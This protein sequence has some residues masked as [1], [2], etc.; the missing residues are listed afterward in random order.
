VETLQ[1]TIAASFMAQTRQPT[2]FPAFGDWLR[3]SRK[4]AGK[5]QQA[6]LND[7]ERRGV[8]ITK[9][10]LS[11]YEGG[12]VPDPVVLAALAD[13]YGESLADAIHTLHQERT[14]N[15]P[16]RPKTNLTF[17]NV[18][19]YIPKKN[20]GTEGA[21]SRGPITRRPDP[22]GA[23][24][25]LQPAPLPYPLTEHEALEAAARLFTTAD[26]LL[27]VA[28]AIMRATARRQI[29]DPR[30]ATPERARADRNRRR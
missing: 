8:R 12:R 22:H 6:V 26:E 29:A 2:R 20:E 18:A 27:T 15:E 28:D 25:S 23:L 16:R 14:K 11:K 5:S 10:A 1:G 4:A 7:L 24:S 13:I 30:R 17:H 19:R 9:G 21:A 3:A